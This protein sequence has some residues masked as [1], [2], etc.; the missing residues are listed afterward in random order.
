MSER[1][2]C[3]AFIAII[4]SPPSSGK[5]VKGLSWISFA[6]KPRMALYVDEIASRIES[7]LIMNDIR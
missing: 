7:T 2:R 1:M 6:F 5:V 3:D 4:E